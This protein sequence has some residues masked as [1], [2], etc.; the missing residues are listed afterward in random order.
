MAGGKGERKGAENGGGPG[1][2]RKSKL[3]EKA[4]KDL[5]EV[6]KQLEGKNKK[7]LEKMKKV[8]EDFGLLVFLFFSFL[9]GG[10]SASKL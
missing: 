3:E 9:I 1:E 5:A 8:T 7:L 2:K 6:S 4:E 10:W